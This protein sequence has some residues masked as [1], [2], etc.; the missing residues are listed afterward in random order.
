MHTKELGTNVLN[1]VLAN[2]EIFHKGRSTDQSVARHY[3]TVEFLALSKENLETVIQTN[4]KTFKETLFGKSLML[5]W[6]LHR[7][8]GYNLSDLFQIKAEVKYGDFYRDTLSNVGIPTT[9]EVI[10][11]L[12]T[13]DK[14]KR[15]NFY[16]QT[17][18][19]AAPSKDLKRTQLLEKEREEIRLKSKEK[20]D[21]WY[22][23]Q[24]F[25]DVDD[26][27]VDES[28][29]LKKEELLRE[30][31][32]KKKK[33]P[34]EQELSKKLE[35]ESQRIKSEDLQERMSW[36]PE[37]LKQLQTSQALRKKTGLFGL[38]SKEPKTYVGY[39]EALKLCSEAIAKQ[40][41]SKVNAESNSV[42]IVNFL[43]LLVTQEG[44][45]RACDMIST[46]VG[47]NNFK[48]IMKSADES[49]RIKLKDK[50]PEANKPTK[51]RIEDDQNKLDKLQEFLYLDKALTYFSGEENKRKVTDYFHETIKKKGFDLSKMEE[52]IS[53]FGNIEKALELWMQIQGCAKK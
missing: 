8:D 20:F 17:V 26:D 41:G 5:G 47:S 43:N 9:D 3:F 15:S 30:E 27:V 39:D 36:Q 42:I 23:Q 14:Q 33:P 24:K 32:E 6:A 21:L 45:S 50:I 11:E 16:L 31:E 49:V 34:Q 28:A 37:I 51:L 19:L 44:K 40:S 46:I 22:S 29:K 12:N 52:V 4:V 25:D 7:K 13:L 2:P 53:K 1:E 18:Q 35:S 38:S 48:N 10:D